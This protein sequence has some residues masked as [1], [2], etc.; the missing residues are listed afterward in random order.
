MSIKE[1]DQNLPLGLDADTRHFLNE[2]RA[3]NGPKL[4]EISI[5]QARALMH[6]GSN[7]DVSHYPVDT[8][9]IDRDG[10]SLHIFS[11]RHV[12]GPLPAVMFF[13]GGGWALGD[14][15]TH[16]R[17]ARE[18]AVGANVAVVFVSYAL[19]PESAY[20]AAVEQCYAATRYIYEQAA[21]LSM[22]PS[23]L[24]VVGDSSGGNLAAAV[25]LMAARRGGPFMRLQIL[26]YPVLDWDI[27]TPSYDAFGEG[28]NLDRETM[29]WFWNLYAP[30]AT[31]R[32][33]PLASLLRATASELADVPPALIV[34]CEYDVLRCEGEA[35]AKKLADA[36]I[37]VEAVRIPGTVHGFAQ[38]DA[39]ANS[40]G[41]LECRTLV[42][43]S[44]RCA[45]R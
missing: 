41:A 2:L 25:T 29:I 31:R 16:E 39:L 21:S 4:H 32:M 36:G 24:A 9:E 20:P 35:Y 28:F 14:L 23:R 18:I 19:A 43:D 45:F 34:T 33:E 42:V 37:P 11:P 13:H 22:D 27:N 5:E 44:L 26:L 15:K 3:S 12:Q 40:P 30:D 7:L 17:L 6:S 1:N 38:T 10:Y 8:Q